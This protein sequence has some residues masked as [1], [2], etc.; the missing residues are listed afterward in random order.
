MRS[1]SEDKEVL[2]D[3]ESNRRTDQLTDSL[4]KEGGKNTNKPRLMD[5]LYNNSSTIYPLCLKSGLQRQI[6]TKVSENITVKL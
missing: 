6:R 3:E 1:E 4:N 5:E 2:K